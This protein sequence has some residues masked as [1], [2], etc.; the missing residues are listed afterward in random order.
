MTTFDLLESSQASSEPAELYRFQIG[1]EVFF[2][3]S[4]DESFLVQGDTYVP[5]PGISRT[6][7][8]QGLDAR[9]QAMRIKLPGDNAF[10]IKWQVRPPGLKGTVTVIRVQKQELPAIGT[11]FSLEYRG[12]VRSV[13]FPGDGKSAIMAITS[14]EASANRPLPRFSYMGMCNHFLYDSGC[15]VDPEL[16]RVSGSVTDETGK[17]ITVPGVSAFPDGTFDGGF[18]KPQAVSD[19]RSIRSQAGDVLTLRSPFK[20]P[21]LSTTV[22]CFKGCDHIIDSDCDLVFDNVIEFGGFAFTPLKNPFQTGL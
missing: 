15:G 14:V 2:F 1:G 5:E 18:V 11:T 16:H 12:V 4:S 3:T 22:D 20:I 9:N 19:F 17:T 13:D 8:A 6:V 7:V 21:V 10:A